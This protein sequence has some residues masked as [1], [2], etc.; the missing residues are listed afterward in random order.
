MFKRLSVLVFVFSFFTLNVLSQELDINATYETKA[1]LLIYSADVSG[2]LTTNTLFS[3]S[4]CFF[5]II[6][7]KYSDDVVEYYK[8]KFISKSY[9]EKADTTIQTAVKTFNTTYVTNAAGNSIVFYIKVT[10]LVNN[11]LVR[12]VYKPWSIYP[13][14]GVLTMPVKLRFPQELDQN[15]N[16]KSLKERLDF[17]TDFTI[18]ATGGLKLQISKYR[19]DYMAFVLGAGLGVVSVNAETT[20]ST[21]TTDGTKLSAWTVA[22]GLIFELEIGSNNNLQ[23]GLLIGGD[24]LNRSVGSDWIYHGKPWMSF[25]VGYSLFNVENKKAKGPISQKIKQ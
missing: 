20:D 8:I 15:G 11:S 2:N 10:E 1:S 14:G 22:G 23:L 7:T 21:I 17:T 5:R 12:K 24:F 18:G 3:D 19:S 9:K 6:G 25:G 13:T 16:N 4:D